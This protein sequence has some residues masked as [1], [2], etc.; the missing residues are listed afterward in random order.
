MF[1]FRHKGVY[2]PQKHIKIE[3]QMKI[4]R[5]HLVTFSPTHTSERIGKAIAEGTRINT[6]CEMN[7]TTQII[8]PYEFPSNELVI[9]TV[10]VYGGHV[11][12]LA[13]QRMQQ[14]HAQNTPALAIVVYGNRA[15]ENALVELS[16]F[17]SSNNFKV[18]GGATFIGEHSYSTTQFPIAQ[19]RPNEDD[20][21]YARVFGEKI[22]QK[23]RQATDID[24][25]YA[26]DV[27]KIQRPTQPLF[28]LLRFLFRVTKLRKSQSA[29]MPRT[30][31]TNESLCNQCHRCVQL[32]P[33]HAIKQN[34][35]YYT[36][37]EKCIR[38]CACVKG[39]PQQARSFQTPFS[40]LLSECFKRQKENRIIL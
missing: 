15:Y 1:F 20:L 26:V 30:P 8:E 3:M 24:H 27:S 19:G 28:P 2:L 29:I 16:G 11:A 6:I 5:I 23:I 17:L 14:L 36:D 9:F 7:A 18:I 22:M 38:C 40:I 25:L 35:E 39:C 32:C 10:P 21:E 37:P 12:K 34:E 13:L 4:E 31:Q 33:T